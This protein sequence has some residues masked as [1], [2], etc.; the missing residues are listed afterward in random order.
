V[1]RTPS[2]TLITSQ[3]YLGFNVSLERLKSRPILR[4]VRKS[5]LRQTLQV[6]VTSDTCTQTI[7]LT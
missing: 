5:A 2:I 7:R 3:W 4:H 6:G 1:Q